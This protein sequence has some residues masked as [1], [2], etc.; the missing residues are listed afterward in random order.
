MRKL[1]K[2]YA[3]VPDKLITP[4]NSGSQNATS[5]ADGATTG[6]R[7]GVYRLDDENVK[8]PALL[9][10]NPGTRGYDFFGNDTDELTAS[11]PHS[12]NQ[13][14]DLRV[15]KYLSTAKQA[16]AAKRCLSVCPLRPTLTDTKKISS[17]PSA[18][19]WHLIP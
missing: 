1:L 19:Q 16:A 15:W 11:T 12:C 8:P 18:M 7:I 2:K 17:A 6:P 13:V 5:V 4:V 3:F 14:I 10:S 9:T